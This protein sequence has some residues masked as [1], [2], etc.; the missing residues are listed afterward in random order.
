[1]QRPTPDRHLISPRAP[2][3]GVWSGSPAEWSDFVRHGRELHGSVQGPYGVAGRAGTVSG[4]CT[5]TLHRLPV[6]TI[7]KEA[8]WRLR[9]VRRRC[10]PFTGF[11]P[12]PSGVLT[13][14]GTTLTRGHRWTQGRPGSRARPIYTHGRGY[15]V[16]K[17][18]TFSDTDSVTVGFRHFVLISG[19]ECGE[20][21]APKQV[22]KHLGQRPKKRCS[23]SVH[24]VKPFQTN[25]RVGR[26]NNPL[27]G[28]NPWWHMPSP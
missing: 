1:M 9:P 5:W 12:T 8:T 20:H 13:F 11:S 27:K 21:L 26:A 28:S 24:T 10:R 3:E 2:D 18:L 4:Q 15:S 23:N 25:R 14:Y 7:S 6:R 17:G 19:E 16:G 22:F